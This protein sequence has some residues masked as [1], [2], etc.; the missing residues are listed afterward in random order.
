MKIRYIYSVCL[1]FL[2]FSCHSKEGET[3]KLLQ[4]WIGKEVIFPETLRPQILY[5]DTFCYDLLKKDYKILLHVNPYGCSEC[6]LK[7][8]NWMELM[9][10]CGDYKDKLAF[11][12]VVNSLNKQ[13][14]RVIAMQNDFNY[15]IFYDVDGKMDE[16]NKFPENEDFRCF[17]LDR[18]NKVKFIGNPVVH[19]QAWN[20]FEKEIKK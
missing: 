14:I 18:D 1:L 4:T 17:L 11:I 2:F 16:L 13:E 8:R 20:L 12:F 6:K 9:N 10:K 3:K 5:R 7:L 15:P 19:P